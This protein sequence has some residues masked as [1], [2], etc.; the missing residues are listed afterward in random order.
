M[1]R[2]IGQAGLDLIK[3]YEGC[4]LTS[5]RCV[6]GVLTIGYGHTYGVKEG[7]KCT[8]AQ[9]EQWLIEDCQK[10]ADYVDNPSYVPVTSQLN[11]NQRDALISFAYNCGQANLKTLCAGRSIA[12][13]SKAILKY[14]KAGGKVIQGLIDRRNEEKKLFDTPVSTSN[15]V[16]LNYKPNQYYTTKTALNIR[17]KPSTSGN[18]LATLPS[19]SRIKNKATT[20]VGNAIWMY[21]GLDNKGNERW[22]CADTGS[23]AYIG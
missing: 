3:K 4:R 10:F 2:K 11:D 6:A 23:K 12:E 1:S 15:H 5:Y 7:Q 9:A 21:I 8:Q 18:K 13:I 17:N 19:G 14:N 16:Q 22:V 20:R